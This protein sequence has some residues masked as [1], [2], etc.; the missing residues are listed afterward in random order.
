MNGKKTEK[1]ANTILIGMNTRVRNIVRYCNALFREKKERSLHFSAIGR[2]IGK[3]VLAVEILKVV[4]A[5]LYQQNRLATVI[6][7]RVDNQKN[8][9]NQR[10]FPKMEV[11][12]S[13]DKFE[14]INE[15]GFQDKIQEDK[16]IE[17]YNIFNLGINRRPF[18]RTKRGFYP[19]RGFRN[20]RTRN[21]NPGNFRRR[22]RSFRRV[23]RSFRSR[24]G[25]V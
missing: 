21:V 12:L 16:R 7:Q 13:L 9:S 3:L 8:V 19:R 15:E 6:Y 25:R 22:G 14:K 24:R 2:A 4:N 20:F 1:D 5:D 17:L 18:N 11:I 10:I 23:F